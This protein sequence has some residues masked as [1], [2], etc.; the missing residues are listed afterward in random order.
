[1]AWRPGKHEGVN[2]GKN[3]LM[4]V[5]PF[6]KPAYMRKYHRKAKENLPAV[7]EAI[8]AQFD[9]KS[10]RRKRLDPRV[11]HVA[12]RALRNALRRAGLDLDLTLKVL[13]DK[14]AAKT[15]KTIAKKA[16][17]LEDNDAQLRAA[18]MAIKLYETAGEI[19]TTVEPAPSNARI[20]M[21]QIDPDGTERW[22]EIG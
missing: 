13:K 6:D 4:P 11:G 12:Q 7:A 19:P 10:S 8:V 14:H 5:K 22:L 3:R 18:E 2:L 16:K 15:M 20:R 21:V 1:M 17:V 9:R